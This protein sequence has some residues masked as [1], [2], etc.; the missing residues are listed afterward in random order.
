MSAREPSAEWDAYAKAEDER[1][2][3]IQTRLK[4]I[5]EWTARELG[6]LVPADRALFYPFAGPDALHAIAMFPG[7][8]RLLLVGLEPVGTLPDPRSPAGG[9]FSRLGTA[10]SDLHRLTFFRTR[11][12]Q[13]DFKKDGVL[14][15]IVAT[16]ARLGGKVSSVATSSSP[17]SARIDWTTTEGKA[18]R[19]D[20]VQLDLANASLKNETAFVAGVRALAPYVTFVKAAM[21]LP[22]QARFSYVRQMITDDSS[23]LVQDDT[24]VPFRHLGSGWAMRFFGRY[25]TPVSPF[26]EFEQA[27]L[28][29]AFEHRAVG[30]MPFGIGYGVE[31]KRSNLL[32]AWKAS[33]GT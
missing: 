32:V 33:K 10:L 21:Y 27:D 3:A 14:G 24:G 23:L 11:E 4:S 22:A 9:T 8:P 31:A 20:Y 2:S 26:E 17:P 13:A 18:R 29:S 28:R 1:W 19:L 15:A 16:V 7:A 25:E 5:Q 12:M 6:P 30:A